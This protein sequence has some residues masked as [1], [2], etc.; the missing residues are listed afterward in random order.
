M[1]LSWLVVLWF[2]GCSAVQTHHAWMGQ[3]AEWRGF[4][5]A[6]ITLGEHRVHHWVGGSGPAVLLLHGFGGDGLV[7]W[8]RVAEM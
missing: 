8:W 1:N 4:E 3:T 5:E 7:T 6:T 2:F